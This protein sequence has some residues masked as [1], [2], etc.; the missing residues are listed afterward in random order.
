MRQAAT[1]GIAAIV[2]AMALAAGGQARAADKEPLVFMT[3]GGIWQ[4]TFEKLAKDYEAETKQRVT[5]I[6][7][8]A[9]EAGLARVIAQKNQPEVDVWSTNMINYE[10]AK[11]EGVIA[12]FDKAA[13]PNA[14]KIKPSLVFSNGVTAWVS[15][16]GLFYRKDLVPFEPKSWED[17]WDP[18]FKGKI[19]A[20]AAT[21]DPGYFP[22]MAALLAG[23]NERNLAPGFA[24]LKTLRPSFVTFFTNNV[25][26]IRLLEAGEVGLIAWGILPNVISYIKPGGNYAFVVPNKP[27]LVA[28]TPLTIIQGTPRKKEAEAFVNYLLSEK[29]QTQ[30]AAAFG[31]LPANPD[32]KGPEVVQSI[33]SNLDGV[34]T[35]DYKYLADN[36]SNTISQYDREVVQ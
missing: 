3:W 26:S 22:T 15:L 8:G 36:L 2:L 21:F 13:V 25:Q 35:M 29:A 12:P 19:G 31:A 33:L 27:L 24:K 1:H 16:R 7:Q 4:Q 18:R 11:T 6:A 23:G 10:R 5:V 32:A 9:G 28:E 34:Y 30:M 17:L 20:P 14:A